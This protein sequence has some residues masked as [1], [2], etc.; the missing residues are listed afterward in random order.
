MVMLADAQ[1]GVPLAVIESGSITSLRTAAAT[2]VAAKYL[3][4]RDAHTVTL[5]GCSVQGETHIAA[6]AADLPLQRA[7][8]VD[9]VPSRA[10]VLAERV[11]AGDRMDATVWTAVLKRI[12]AVRA[13]LP[14]PWPDSSTENPPSLSVEQLAAQ[15][16]GGEGVQIVDARQR[17]HM[18]RHRDLMAGATWRDPD[19]V[20]DWIAE[21]SP[22]KLV[23]V[24]CSY[25]FDVGRNV[26]STL[27]AHGF[28]AR[29]L[30]GG[31]SAWYA[32][33]GPR[34]LKPTA[35]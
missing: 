18:S 27:I 10:E 28:G 25:G 12:E 16:S 8:L 21:L 13:E 11:A 35:E 14:P 33:G 19:R 32:A 9:S 2:A 7:F 22:E 1:N 3:A 5:V 30:R 6:L 17:D 23:V 34:A 24:Y 29:Y 20:Q 4:R 26:A 15:I 31:L